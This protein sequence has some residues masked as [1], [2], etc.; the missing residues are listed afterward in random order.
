M[1][2]DKDPGAKFDEELT[3]LINKEFDISR[4]K[5]YLKDAP[6]F[7]P[8]YAG[9]S[10][11]IVLLHYLSEVDSTIKSII[12]NFVQ[13]AFNSVKARDDAVLLFWDS[14]DVKKLPN[15][16]LDCDLY[17]TTTRADIVVESLYRREKLSSELD[18]FAFLMMLNPVNTMYVALKV[19]TDHPQWKFFFPFK[20]VKLNF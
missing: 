20:K 9:F 18:D 11:S 5:D 2:G 12:I 4:T 1:D 19:I 16:F 6:T 13:H 7:V 14:E 8:G 3:L 17:D 10:K 15:K